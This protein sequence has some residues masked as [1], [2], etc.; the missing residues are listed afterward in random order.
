MIKFT[1]A[2][3]T[4]DCTYDP[5]D[6]ELEVLDKSIPD[7]L[8]FEGQTI[9][10]KADGIYLDP[11][12][13]PEIQLLLYKKLSEN[14]VQYIKTVADYKA[15]GE[16]RRLKAIE[17]NRQD[18][19]KWK[20]IVTA[21]V[22]DIAEFTPIIKSVESLQPQTVRALVARHMS[23]VPEYFAGEHKFGTLP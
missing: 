1:A 19:E 9:L 13:V 12:N 11:L 3:G 18:F 17:Q 21:P 6:I 7:G 23:V 20:D 16:A 2:D 22:P 15:E 14:R 4:I 5:E 8:K 10:S